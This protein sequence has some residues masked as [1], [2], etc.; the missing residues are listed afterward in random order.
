MIFITENLG[1]S[2]LLHRSI[3]I[4]LL[5]AH[6]QIVE[7]L[8]IPKEISEV[9][10]RCPQSTKSHK[11]TGDCIKYL[12]LVLPNCN[13]FQMLNFSRILRLQHERE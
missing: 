8:Y 10:L 12:N 13:S 9:Y 4:I 1:K 6:T 11:K 5:T 2:S 7:T 3:C